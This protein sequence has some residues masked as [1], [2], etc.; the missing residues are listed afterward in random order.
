MAPKKNN[1]YRYFDPFGEF[2]GPDFHQFWGNPG[3]PQQPQPRQAAGSGVIL[4]SDGYI[5]TNNHVVNG[6]DQIS[7]VLHDNN[8]YEA[9]IIGVDPSTDIAVLKIEADRLVFIEF[10]NSDSVEVGEWVLA[11]G[12]PF[13]LSSTVTAGIV[14]A[15]ARNINILEDNTAIESFIQTDAAVN[16]G[17]S[18]GALVNTSG[19]LI[20][21]NT[22][23][24]SPTGAFAGY[25]FAVPSNLV[26]K[27]VDDLRTYGIVQRGFLGVTISN[28]DQETARQKGLNDLKGILIREILKGSAADDAGL[29]EGDIIRTINGFEVNSA[30]T[31]QEIVGRYRPGDAIE[32]EYFRDGKFKK[33]SVVL[34]NKNKNTDLLSKESVEVLELLGAQFREL[35]DDEKKKYKINGGVVVENLTDGKFSRYT[36]MRKGFVITRIDQ[37]K[38]EKVADISRILA[39]KQG[40]VMMEGFYPDYP[41]TYYYA[42]GM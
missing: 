16:P 42:F 21:I 7:V 34:K 10:A 32:V 28:V 18:G 17:N 2:F 22:A 23:I 8:E 37:Q 15:K 9:K 38:V 40:G 24:A 26:Q 14:S 13:N 39:N 3:Q 4:S 31:L 1:T 19:Q 11:V 20:G 12:N 41:G 25:S 6:A 27:V 29:K 5:V 35:S 36:D 33:A 30:P